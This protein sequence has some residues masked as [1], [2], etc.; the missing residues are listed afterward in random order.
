MD[1]VVILNEIIDEAKKRKLSRVVFKVDFEKTFNL[2]DWSYLDAMM[3][4][5][6]FGGWR[7]WIRVSISTATTSV[8][9]NGCPLKEFNLQRGLRQGK[10][11]GLWLP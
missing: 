9:V 6:N 1:G 7:N 3:A 5:L 2:V 8:L 10:S 11:C 4:G